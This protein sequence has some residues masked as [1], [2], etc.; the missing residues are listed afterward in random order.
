MLTMW[1]VR[2][3]IVAMEIFICAIYSNNILSVE[4]GY[5]WVNIRPIRIDQLGETFMDFLMRIFE[6]RKLKESRLQFGWNFDAAEWHAIPID[7]TAISK[8]WK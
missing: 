6:K 7:T 5:Y 8:I 4:I 1:T 2:V 3:V